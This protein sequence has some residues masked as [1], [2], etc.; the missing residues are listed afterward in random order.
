MQ[1]PGLVPL[2]VVCRSAAHLRLR[3]SRM[4]QAIT[5]F[6]TLFRRPDDN[7]DDRPTPPADVRLWQAELRMFENLYAWCEEVLADDSGIN[8]LTAHDDAHYRDAI[9][10]LHA[11]SWRAPPAD[12]ALPMLCAHPEIQ[13]LFFRLAVQSGLDVDE[14]DPQRHRKFRDAL[15]AL[16][17]GFPMAPTLRAFLTWASTGLA[18]ELEEQFELG[19]RPW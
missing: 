5:H 7:L 3:V 17:K 18:A 15:V 11:A 4:Q 9:D 8:V 13:R 19:R 12:A 6:I 14:S 16:L 1:N 2:P 10:T